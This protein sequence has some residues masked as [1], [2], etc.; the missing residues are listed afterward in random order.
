[1]MGKECIT[2]GTNVLTEYLNNVK[3]AIVGKHGVEN[4]EDSTNPAIRSGT[5]PLGAFVVAFLFGVIVAVLYAYGAAK[6]SYCY[7][8]SQGI[9][10]GAAFM[11]SALAFF[12]C[13][14][15]YPFYGLYLNP[16]C[17]LASV[18]NKMVGGSRKAF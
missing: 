8:I 11:W 5:L 15:Y 1:M 2:K 6:L 13:G 10:P 17:A 7:S 16:T 4:F 9:T 18:R 12:F 3:N 14:W